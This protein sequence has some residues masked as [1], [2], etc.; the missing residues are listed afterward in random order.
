M[1]KPQEGFTNSMFGSYAYDPIIKR[2]HHHPLVRMNTLIDWSFV[3]EEVLDRYSVK[4]QHAINPLRLFKILIIQSFYNLSERD[5]MAHTEFN[6][7]ARYFVGLGLTEEVPHWTE[8]GKFKER[9]GVDA[10]E[11]L[12]Y[13]V[14][15]E[16]QRLGITLSNKRTV[17]ATDIKATVDLKRCAKDR[18][19]DDDKGYVDRNTSDPDARF[20]KKHTKKGW[21]GYKSH[22]NQEVETELVTAVITTDASLTDE[23]QL[24]P[25]IDMERNARGEDVIR[26]QGGDKGYVGHTEEL[27][28]RNIFDYVIPRDNMTKVKEKK[29]KNTHYLHLKKLRYK[30]EQ[31][32][33]EAKNRHGMEKAR[34]RG[35][36]KV[37]I[38]CLLI[39][40]TMNLKRIVALLVPQIV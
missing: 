34:H 13:R 32:F 26:K 10:F 14:L 2:N 5:V 22:M 9:I 8:L 7:L 19:D 25:L 38:H 31:K 40:L 18:H 4:G 23:S 17:D 1:F 11:S 20:G 15:D 24:V 21:Y 6:I 35:R 12:F 33:G 37:H 16:A 39:Y 29:D 36:L 3:E 30:V 28:E 27:K